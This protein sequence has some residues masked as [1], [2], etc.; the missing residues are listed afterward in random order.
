MQTSCPLPEMSSPCARVGMECQRWQSPQLWPVLLQV[1]QELSL[2]KV[3]VCMSYCP[4]Q[5]FRACRGFKPHHKFCFLSPLKDAVKEE[6]R[7]GEGDS[8]EP[9]T[10]A[11]E[12]V[13]VEDVFL[14]WDIESAL[15]PLEGEE[16]SWEHRPYLIMLTTQDSDEIKTF[17]GLD[18]CMESFFTFLMSL[19]EK[20]KRYI[21]LAHN[22]RYGPLSSTF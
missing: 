13:E 14:Y 7:R 6:G 18:S 9:D 19:P 12:P 10:V 20:G 4:P 1:R 2:R 16:S 21:L 11:R 5:V 3:K 8:G 17:E 15:L 22:S